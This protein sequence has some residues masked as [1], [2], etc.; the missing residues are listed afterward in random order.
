MEIILQNKPEEKRRLLT[1]LE[2]FV[3]EHHHL[4]PAAVQAADLALEEHLTNVMNYAYDDGREHKI[5]VRLEAGA[6]DLV[7]E[8]E[9]DG[10]PFDPTQVPKVDT[11]LPLEQ[12][13]IGG[14]GIH[15][16]R[17]CMDEIRYERRGN[18]NVLRMVKRLAVAAP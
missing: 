17:G 12:K 2:D 1:A 8:V 16:I 3:C 5:L 18:Q 14:L 6:A 10:R 11:S 15:L 7:I 13:P 4:P 9:D